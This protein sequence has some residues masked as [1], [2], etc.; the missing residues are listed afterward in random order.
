[1]T[2]QDVSRL[3]QA[4]AVFFSLIMVVSMMAIGGAAFA[5]GAAADVSGGDG[6]QNPT[7]TNIS[8]G[9][10]TVTQTVTVD[11]IS[12]D[13]AE[14]VTIDG[15]SG[16]NLAGSDVVSAT[17]SATDNLT[18]ES[19]AVVGYPAAGIVSVNVSGNSSTAKID[20]TLTV[21]ITYNT[22]GITTQNGAT[23]TIDDENTGTDADSINTN[24]DLTAP[25][26]ITVTENNGNS[27]DY[28]TDQVAEGGTVSVEPGT[29]SKS[30][31]ISTANITLEGPNAGTPGYNDRGEEAIIT[32]G[33]NVVADGAT[34]DGLQVENDDT[35]GIR[36]GPNT[37]PSNVT[38]KNNNITNVTGATAG[39]RG[40]GNGIQLQFNNVNG[41]TGENIQIL[42]NKI[43]NISTADVPQGTDSTA[44]G[45]N[46]LPRG[47][48]VDG[49]EIAGNTFADI[50]PG[51]PG[52][53]TADARAISVDTQKDDGQ[54]GASAGAAGQVS[55][56]SITDNMITS[57]SSPDDVTAVALFEDSRL[58]P[59][60]GVENFEIVGNEFS[61]FDGA[62][63]TNETA[64]FIG[65]YETLGDEHTISQNNILDG[66]VGRFSESQSGFDP[67]NA[68][69]L[70]ATSNWWGNESGPK[71]AQA[72]VDRVTISGDIDFNPVL[73][74]PAD[75]GGQETT[76]QAESLKVVPDDT[77]PQAGNAATVKI[78]ALDQFGNEVVWNN[79]QLDVN[80][81]AGTLSFSYTDGENVT[82]E[83]LNRSRSDAE[84]PIRATDTADG[85]NV[86]YNITY[87]EIGELGITAFDTG[88]DRTLSQS[89]QATQTYTGS[90]DDVAVTS[91]TDQVVADGSDTANVT[92]QLVD[93]N[94]DP[95]P[96]SGEDVRFAVSNNTAAGVSDNRD[97]ETDANGTATLTLNATNSGETVTV[98]GFSNSQDDSAT[99]TTVAGDV[100][101]QNST[102]TLNGN[103]GDIEE[104]AGV[105]VA[106]D[107][108]AAVTLND[109]E[110][111]AIANRDVTITANGSNV[112][113]ITTNESGVA[114]TTVTLPEEKGTTQLNVTGTAFNASATGTASINVTAIAENVSAL[115][116]ADDVQASVAPNSE[117]NTVDIEAVDEFGNIN[118]SSLGNDVTLESGDT[119]VI[120]FDGSASSSNA[121]SSGVASFDVDANG[122]G[123]TTLSA[124]IPGNL[125]NATQQITVADPAA[126]E[127]TVPHN[128]ATTS[129]ADAN[130][131]T[132]N[133][134]T[135]EAQFVDSDGDALGIDGENITFARQSG[136]AAELNQSNADFTKTTD[137]NGN[138]T[139]D[140]NGTDTTGETTFIALAENFSVQGSAAVTTTGAA[141]TVDVSPETDTLSQNETTNVT[142]QF[143]DTEG[144]NVPRVRT[145]IQLSADSGEVTDSPQSTAV[146]DGS[147]VATFTYNGTEAGQANLTALG[148]GLSGT[149]T[150]QVEATGTVEEDPV[151]QFDDNGNGEID[152]NE[153]IS[154]VIAF[155]QGEE[156]VSRRDAI[157]A[158][159]AFNQN[160]S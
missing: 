155:N 4:H 37:V 146:S 83:T 99:I 138:V 64:V 29:Y 108:A 38:I 123:T 140:V 57:L 86:T 139:I 77:N 96:R 93:Q 107:H 67:A 152:R 71:P 60:I 151:R 82:D 143:I 22:T 23:V 2:G 94:D 68:D 154:A 135:V 13:S 27:I 9:S 79:S 42:D 28:A 132:V 3:E 32:Q 158:V 16:S 160:Q 24:F 7:A 20:G 80:A 73:D 120:D 44:I 134:V 39:P 116:F 52:S 78:V 17:A 92:L 55:G 131:A 10:E 114:T 26:S 33:V 54:S 144:R 145:S 85:Y 41:E 6:L 115:R 156:G 88:T 125:T 126:I 76:L 47:N 35:N 58:N 111:N 70:N 142:T 89:S 101:S 141:D 65:G 137:A 19:N 15:F 130:G 150:V 75:E 11:V 48:D 18:V 153:A 87:S 8:V 45:V 124:T 66:A 100:S 53:E 119:G 122:T 90:I 56:L 14:N 128:V 62:A 149:A 121:T 36:L 159:I 133:Q 50:E 12:D 110:G 103:I 102:F 117:D 118:T 91:D 106:T 30:V 84:V 61:N 95:V 148:G 43:S 157:A 98:T 113:T 46:V 97:P 1:M 69:V 34:L 112:A 25:D 81:T 40:V 31:T 51:T 5:G 109:T 63:E 21:D 136:S 74:A 105:K 72:P 104:S 59:R 129:A 147:V 127:L 49:L